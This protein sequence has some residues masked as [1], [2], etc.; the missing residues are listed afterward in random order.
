MS[1]KLLIVGLCG[2]A[3]SGKDTAARYLCVDHGFTR[4]GLADGV[5]SAFRDLDGPTGELTKEL[6]AA[7]LTQRWALQRLGT[8]ARESLTLGKAYRYLWVDVLMC[9]IQYLGMIHPT[10]RLRFVVPDLRFPYEA[11]MLRIYARERGGYF[12]AWKLDRPG[13]GLNGDA[14][15]HKSETSLD[16]IRAD[17]DV[18]NTGG[19]LDLRE[20]V[21][22]AVEEFMARSETANVKPEAYAL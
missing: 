8:D 14:G 21:D 15:E 17:A 13:S 7:S 19:L 9:K 12:E 2:L 22:I 1:D 20:S 18:R 10:P 4:L 6:E 5:R 16:A 3:R 11:D